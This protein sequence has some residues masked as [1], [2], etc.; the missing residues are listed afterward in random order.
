MESRA[1]TDTLID[2]PTGAAPAPFVR[3]DVRGFLD[4]LNAAPGPKTHELDAP[5]ARQMFTMLGSVAELP[6]G[7]LATI[8]DLSIPG[9]AGTI[10]ARL[11]DVAAAREPGPALVFY[12]GGGFVIGD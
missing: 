12:H 7:E 1:M 9:P 10:P 6:I 3:P 8:V 11:F 2:A 5:T 4:Y